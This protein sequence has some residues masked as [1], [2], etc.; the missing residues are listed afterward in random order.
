M[1]SCLASLKYPW[2]LFDMQGELF[3]HLYSHRDETAR[4][5]ATAIL[6][7]TDGPIWVGAG[8]VIRDFAKICGPAYIGTHSLVGDYAFI[9]QSSLESHSQVGAKAEVVRSI[10]LS[11]SSLHFGYLADSIVGNHV[12]IGAGILTANKRLD[13]Q[14]ISVEVKGQPKSSG[15]TQ[16]GVMIGDGANLGIG[17]KTMPG[18]IIGSQA[19]IFPSTTLFAQVAN[20]ETVK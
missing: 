8:A 12:Q 18:V 10:I 6:D 7:E 13:R 3:E 4:I 1:E 2:H 5:S 14:P 9:R 19:T 16:L 17:V 11:H 20:N 15:R